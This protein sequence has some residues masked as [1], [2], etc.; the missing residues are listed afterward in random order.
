MNP[1]S[2]C[3]PRNPWLKHFFESEHLP[4]VR[5]VGLVPLGLERRV[6]DFID[7]KQR[8]RR[9]NGMQR[10]RFL[11]VQY[12]LGRSIFELLNQLHLAVAERLHARYCTVARAQ[13]TTSV[14]DAPDKCFGEAELRRH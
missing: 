6:V 4:D 13:W 3:N 11:Y 9:A 7:P 2:P 14:R 12:C 10:A 5:F 8:Q 1:I